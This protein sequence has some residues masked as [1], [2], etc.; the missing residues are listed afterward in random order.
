MAPHWARRHPHHCGHMTVV[1]A[2][3]P[4]P[5][6]PIPG[7]MGV[8]DLGNLRRCNCSNA[9][10]YQMAGARPFGPRCPDH[11]AHVRGAR[12]AQVPRIETAISIVVI[13][14][15]FAPTF[16]TKI[17]RR[18]CGTDTLWDL[19]WRLFKAQAVPQ[20]SPRNSARQPWNFDSGIC[21]LG[22][23][24]IGLQQIGGST[25]PKSQ[26]TVWEFWPSRPPD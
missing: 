17:I 15:S 21:T 18:H 5:T 12:P 11:D 9:M 10:P 22:S 3:R 24:A 14:P 2:R 19:R 6:D 16:Q 26:F 4:M 8:N 20:M 7:S 13:S 1:N 25:M 23:G